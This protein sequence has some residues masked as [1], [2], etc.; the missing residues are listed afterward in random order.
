MTHPDALSVRAD[1]RALYVDR[2]D[3]L[4]MADA[5]DMWE[6]LADRAAAAAEIANT[7][8]AYRLLGGDELDLAATAETIRRRY[9]DV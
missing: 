2:V 9:A 8:A 1:V 4:A 3:T 5:Y 6:T 7:R